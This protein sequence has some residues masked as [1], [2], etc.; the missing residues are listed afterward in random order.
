MKRAMASAATPTRATSIPVFHKI[1]PRTGSRP[2]AR[3]VGSAGS[4]VLSIVP[5]RVI[6]DRT[7]FPLENPAAVTG[8]RWS[9]IRGVRFRRAGSRRTGSRRA[10]SG[11]GI[12]RV[13]KHPL[14]IPGT[15]QE[16]NGDHGQGQQDKPAHHDQENEHEGREPEG[17]GETD[18]AS[19]D[20][21]RGLSAGREVV[22][23]ET[24]SGHGIRSVA[25][26][27]TPILE[28]KARR[29]GPGCILRY[30]HP[31]PV[32]S[33]RLPTL[34]AVVIARNEALNIE[35]C[36][37]SLAFADERLVIDGGSTDGTPILAQAR[38][39]RVIIEADWQGFGVQRQRAQALARG[40]WI[41]M[42]D[43]DERVSPDLA[44]EIRRATAEADLSGI[45]VFEIPRLTSVF[46][47]FIRHSGW[48][49]DPVARLYARN[50]AGYDASRVH[51][52]LIIPPSIETGRLTH[53]LLHYSYRTLD[54]YLE[55]SARYAQ[56]WAHER[57]AQ[58]A[59]ANLG[60]GLVHAIGCFFRM[61]VVHG[62]FRD[63]PEGFLLA[64]LSA[65]STFIKYAELWLR[66]R[67]RTGDRHG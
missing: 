56:E 67:N 64:V 38:G 13:A 27:A 35:A 63:G 37:D 24:V 25:G 46:G 52:R 6:L 17:E 1:R 31:V 49:P 40:E 32:R 54:Q 20:A 41:L 5:E 34:S 36:L 16:R 15:D 48:Y 8:S 59:R 4:G 11:P 22:D 58:G 47:R 26:L 55:K 10:R 7:P 62:G 18:E 2:G 21:T 42:V 57:E 19:E 33:P 43:A 14:G 45:R 44:E 30:P 60:Q 51:E 50:A 9:G 3:G 28:R 53:P 61:M 12:G 66:G 65:H 39:A 23:L 29:Y